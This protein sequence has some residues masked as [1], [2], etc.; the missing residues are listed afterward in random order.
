MITSINVGIKASSPLPPNVDLNMEINPRYLS[1]TGFV[2]PIIV[3]TPSIMC[4]PPFSKQLRTVTVMALLDTGASR[5]CISDTIAADLELSPIGFSQI[6]TAAG[7]KIFPDYAVDILFPNAN[8]KSFLNLAVGSCQLPY[9]KN[10]Q[11]GNI[12][13]ETNFG[14]LIGRDMMERWNIVWN[15]PTSSVFISD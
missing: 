11:S 9:R 10:P 3:Q 4:S 5:T 13:E 8:M 12:M 14:V 6:N 1:S 15:G 7:I 2:V